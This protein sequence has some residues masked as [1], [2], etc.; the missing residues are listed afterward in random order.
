MAVARKASAETRAKISAAGKARWAKDGVA[1]RANAERQRLQRL[2]LAPALKRCS[3]CGIEYPPTKDFFF[4]HDQAANGLN[5]SCKKCCY[6]RSRAYVMAHREQDLE[7]KR[8]YRKRN[9]GVDR[10]YYQKNKSIL[11]QK[12]REYERKHWVSTLAR[13]RKWRKEHPERVQVW[14]RNRRAKLKGSNGTHSLTDIC[15]LLKSQ[16]GQCVYCRA[17]IRESFQV[18]H[19]MP[20][21]KGGSNDPSNLQLL[22]KSCNLLKRDK[23]PEQ[24]LKELTFG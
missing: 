23:L 15:S 13:S 18:D 4:C 22:C 12:M 10:A 5:P 20:V 21:S 1:L 3:K 24:F 9:P 11:L 14:V 7:Y 16:N 17:D 6:A 19:I 8:A 2:A